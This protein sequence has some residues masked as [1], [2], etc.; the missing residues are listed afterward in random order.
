M[1]AWV[2]ERE[3]LLVWTEKTEERFYLN[4]APRFQCCDSAQPFAPIWGTSFWFGRC[5][6]TTQLIPY[7]FE[8]Q[9]PFKVKKTGVNRPAD[10]L[11]SMLQAIRLSRAIRPP[12][13]TYGAG[14][15]KR[16]SSSPHI[17]P[18]PLRCC[19]SDDAP[20]RRSR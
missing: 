12:N 20:R 5:T 18:W 1:V 6:I 10:R 16:L 7:Q 2:G 17:G 15:A 13:E 9:G 4:F 11:D 3:H 19:P 14:P 8:S